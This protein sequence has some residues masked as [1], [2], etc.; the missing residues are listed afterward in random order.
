MT[1]SGGAIRR[2]TMSFDDPAASAR[3]NLIGRVGYRVARRRNG[4]QGRT[5]PSSPI[6]SARRREN[7]MKLTLL[8][9]DAAF[10]TRA[11]PSNAAGLGLKPWRGWSFHGFVGGGYER[12]AGQVPR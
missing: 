1:E 8:H 5:R 10:S 2:A 4:H 3:T 6:W 7:L 12:A 11:V 9:H